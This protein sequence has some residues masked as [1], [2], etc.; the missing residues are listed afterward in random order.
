[1]SIRPEIAVAGLAVG[2]AAALLIAKMKS[3][4]AADAGQ[5]VGRAAVN[6]VDGVASGTII[7]IGNLLG[8]PETTTPDSVNRCEAAKAS[9]NCFD[10]MT[11]CTAGDYLKWR[12]NNDSLLS[13]V[14]R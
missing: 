2:I 3:T 12:W 13:S 8:V 6:L 4:S 9:G 5:S 7:G 11:Y 14:C 1:M 10:A